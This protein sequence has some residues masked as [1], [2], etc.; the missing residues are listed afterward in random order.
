MNAWIIE[1]GETYRIFVDRTGKMTHDEVLVR[2]SELL[3]L[4]D[5][6]SK[7]TDVQLRSMLRTRKTRRHWIVD[8]SATRLHTGTRP[9]WDRNVSDDTGLFTINISAEAV[10]ELK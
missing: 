7:S 2:V 3:F 1:D 6:T 5:S 9:S 8:A 4:F 10:V